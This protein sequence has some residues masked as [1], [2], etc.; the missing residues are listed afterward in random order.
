MRFQSPCVF[1]TLHSCHRSTAL[2]AL[3]LLIESKPWY[4]AQHFTEWQI[5]N[6]YTS[7]FVS[8]LALLCHTCNLH[9][10]L[11]AVSSLFTVFFLFSS[12]M[13]SAATLFLSL[14]KYTQLFG[15]WLWLFSQNTKLS[16]WQFMFIQ[17][18]DA[19]RKIPWRRQWQSTPALLPGKS[20]GRRSLICYSPWGRKESDTTERLHILQPSASWLTSFSVNSMSVIQLLFF[21][22]PAVFF[23]FNSSNYLDIN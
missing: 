2:P 3:D 7:L 14:E 1:S 9:S 13:K 12:I 22:L 18:L 11:L 20:H 21:Y 5:I 6:E 4:A 10:S 23:F 15:L 8:L 16:H 17:S 19:Y